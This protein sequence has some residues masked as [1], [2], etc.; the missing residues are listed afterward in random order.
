MTSTVIP[1]PSGEPQLDQHLIKNED[2]HQASD[3]E[4]DEILCGTK[5]C[6]TLH[7]ISQQLQ[8]D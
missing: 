1:H 7:S 5:S 6:R 4:I 3:T 2:K 8:I